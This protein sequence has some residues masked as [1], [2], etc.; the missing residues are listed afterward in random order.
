MYKAKHL[1]SG[2]EIIILDS[3][4]MEQ[5]D[6]LRGL[7]KIGALVC[8]YCNQ[9]VRVRAGEIK[10]WHFA[11]K[12]LGNCP[13]EKE[14]PILLKARAVLYRWLVG[15]FGPEAVNIEK[16][17]ES[18]AFR[19]HIDCWVVDDH[20]E[21]GY[22]ILDRRVPPDERKDLAAGNDE[23]GGK[24]N[25]VTVIDLLKVDE[26]NSQNRLHLTTTEREF[27]RESELDKAWQ[28]H[29]DQLGGSLH[30]LDGD[31]ETLI[32]YR[33]LTVVHLPQLYTGTRLLNRL[34]E[35]QVSSSTGEFIHPGEAEQFQK[36]V[37]QI[38]RDQQKVEERLRKGEN[39]LKRA[40]DL[41][42]A[43]SFQE[44]DFDKTRP[45]KR[46]GTCK[47]CGT[48]TSD[49]VTYFGQTKGCIC[50]RCKDQGF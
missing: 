42:L 13:F 34:S 10:R 17:P 11:H 33:N 49:W 2:Q 21:F 36:R 38:E 18:A 25:W 43:L 31:R 5:I 20:H 7:D 23:I 12:H 26:T 41:K 27:I 19:R 1:P 4:W 24:L 16:K 50:R 15:K 6:Y 45:K 32:T 8:P 14:S 39:F 30:Y 29:F 48:V 44:P 47:F 9:P 28:T 22:W 35:L 46:E 37:R 40:S 3:R